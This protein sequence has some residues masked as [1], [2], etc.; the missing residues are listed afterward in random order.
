MQCFMWSFPIELHGVLD[1]RETLGF[2][3]SGD[4]HDRIQTN[5]SVVDADCVRK[6]FIQVDI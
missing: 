6:I 1:G 5:A 3:Y 4:A 2:L